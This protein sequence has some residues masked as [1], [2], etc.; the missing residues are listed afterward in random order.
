M[1]FLLPQPKKSLVLKYDL[2][3]NGSDGVTRRMF[4]W[5]KD[6][7]NPLHMQMAPAFDNLLKQATSRF[8]KIFF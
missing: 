2:D 3:K 1:Q 4:K 6:N 5:E 7:M 8:F